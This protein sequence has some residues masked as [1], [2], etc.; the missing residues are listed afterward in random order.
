MIRYYSL[1]EEK[2]ANDAV[3]ISIDD[4]IKYSKLLIQNNHTKLKTSITITSEY[5]PLKE[6]D[7]D[8]ER[9]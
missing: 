3:G 9:K 2:V 4:K 5:E 7:S 6:D 8:G 1:E